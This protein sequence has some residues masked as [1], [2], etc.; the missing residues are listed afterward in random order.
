M[1]NAEPSAATCERLLAD[2]RP[3]PWAFSAVTDDRSAVDAYRCGPPACA[4]GGCVKP[5]RHYACDRQAARALAQYV[6]PEERAKT[7]AW[8]AAMDGAESDEDAVAERSMYVTCL[9]MALQSGR[10]VAPFTRPPPPPCRP[11][12]PLRDL[13]DV[14][15]YRRVQIECRKR[16]LY[17]PA[18]YAQPD[19][20]AAHRPADFFGQMPAPND[21]VFCYGAAF[22]TAGDR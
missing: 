8:L 15:T 5:G 1:S 10:L 12:R 11:L 17:D 21:G 14:H 20:R 9:L 19:R 22:S 13:V 2:G 6:T 18:V 3:Q 16:R 4:P 7:V